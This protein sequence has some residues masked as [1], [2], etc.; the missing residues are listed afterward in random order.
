MKEPSIVNANKQEEYKE[1]IVLYK[2]KSRY[3]KHGSLAFFSGG[4][5]CVIGQLIFRGY[6]A[7]FQL[8]DETATSYMLITLIAIA[9]L[10][11]GMGFY[12]KGAQLFGAGLLVPIT[13]FANAM[14]ATALE[15]RTEGLLTGVGS[16]LFRL[17]GPVL[18]FGIS[19]AY[20]VSFSRLLI[21]M[22]LH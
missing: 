4:L 3:L 1:N 9:V 22:I 17:I 10:A 5:I 12:R 14:A 2:P 6:H 16:N 7:L 15:Y 19:T 13:G 8:S 20:L 21:R 18:V 11:T